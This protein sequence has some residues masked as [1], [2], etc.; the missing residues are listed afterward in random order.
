MFSLS[1]V[2]VGLYC[3]QSLNSTFKAYFGFGVMCLGPEASSNFHHRSGGR[4]RK[5]VV[6]LLDLL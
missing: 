1:F 4:N 2:G 3:F 5:V 6:L